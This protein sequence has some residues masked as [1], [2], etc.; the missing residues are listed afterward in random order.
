M[1]GSSCLTPR[2]ARS[3]AR[4]CPGCKEQEHI[5]RSHHALNGH[6]SPL[7][8]TQPHLPLSHPLPHAGRWL[9]TAALHPEDHPARLFPAAHVHTALQRCCPLGCRQLP[10]PSASRVSQGSAGPMSSMLCQASSQPGR[11]FA[12]ATPGSCAARAPRPLLGLQGR[13]RPPGPALPSSGAA[14]THAAQHVLSS[15][16]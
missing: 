4:L 2:A 8:G 1:Q 11:E 13:C 6:K 14:R 5:P 7:H 3:M 15:R 9:L 16:R 10:P 12:P